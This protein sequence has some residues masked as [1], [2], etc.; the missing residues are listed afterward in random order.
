M[1]STPCDRYSDSGRI[2]DELESAGTLLQ[3][4]NQAREEAL[5]RIRDAVVRGHHR[6]SV[7]EMARAAGV[8]RVLAHRV[9]REWAS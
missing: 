1:D 9:L 6:L 4:A 2:L 7:T 5:A 3:H 8:S